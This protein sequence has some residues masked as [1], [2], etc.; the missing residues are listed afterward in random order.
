MTIIDSTA[1]TFYDNNREL[2]ADLAAALNAQILELV[3]AG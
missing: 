2:A 1:N 3:A